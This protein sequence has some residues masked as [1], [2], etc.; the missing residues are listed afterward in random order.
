M[1]T[2]LDTSVLIAML[3][4]DDQFHDWSLE[5]FENCKI[6]GPAIISDMVYCEFCVGMASKE[7]ADA[8]VEAFGIERSP[9]NDEALFRAGVAFKKYRENRGQKAN[10]LP[11][12][13]I[14]AFADVVGAPLI[15]SNPD[16]FLRYF[17][18]LEIIRP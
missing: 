12:F 14:G 5:E 18:N 9:R 10:V 1:T 8:A 3:K 13:I 16:D 6:K 2:F 17:P 4:E 15:T 7:N 11:D